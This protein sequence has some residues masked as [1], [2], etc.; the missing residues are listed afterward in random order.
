[1]CK[2]GVFPAIFMLRG[3]SGRGMQGFYE[4]ACFGSHA[5]RF[6]PGGVGFWLLGRSPRFAA[7][8]VANPLTVATPPIFIDRVDLNGS[9]RTSMKSALSASQG[10]YRLLSLAP[11]RNFNHSLAINR[12]YGSFM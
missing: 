5:D 9:W 4:N 12:W 6:F 2:G 8:A 10:S 11:T 7:T 3:I 1:M